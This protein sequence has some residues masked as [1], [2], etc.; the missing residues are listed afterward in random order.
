[1]F[2]IGDVGARQIYVSIDLRSG[3]RHLD[4]DSKGAAI[5][6][7]LNIVSIKF[8]FCYFSSNS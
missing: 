7:V 1:M 5:L 2:H 8:P 4:D 3:F 6:V